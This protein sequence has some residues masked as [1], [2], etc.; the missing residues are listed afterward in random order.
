MVVMDS[1]EHNHLQ[2][3]SLGHSHY[4]LTHVRDI[5]VRLLA[6][7]IPSTNHKMYKL[8]VNYEN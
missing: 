8:E 1:T 3:I 6:R 2:A 5:E 4:S 7:Q